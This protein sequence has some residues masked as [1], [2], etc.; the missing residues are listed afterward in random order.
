MRRVDRVVVGVSRAE[1]RRTS[2]RFA[3]V[4]LVCGLVILVLARLPLDE[5]DQALELFWSHDRTGANGT[6]LGHRMTLASSLPTTST[7][8]LLTRLRT[9]PSTGC[10]TTL[11]SWLT[12]PFT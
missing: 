10:C 6:G 2:A 8:S 1:D 11:R 5:R 12:P 7:L 4:Q 3:R 9:Q